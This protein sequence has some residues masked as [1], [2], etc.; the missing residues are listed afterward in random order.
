M[1][2]SPHLQPL[3]DRL[4]QLSGLA[5]TL[6]TVYHLEKFPVTDA[7]SV[8]EHPPGHGVAQDL[9]FGTQRLLVGQRLCCLGFCRIA[10]RGAEEIELLRAFTMARPTPCSRSLDQPTAFTFD[11]RAAMAR[12]IPLTSSSLALDDGSGRTALDNRATAD[13]V[14]YP[15]HRFAIDG[16]RARATDHGSTSMNRA[17]VRVADENDGFHVW[18]PLLKRRRAPPATGCAIGSEWQ[19]QCQAVRGHVVVG[20]GL[21]IA[22]LNAPA[23]RAAAGRCAR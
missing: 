20:I 3:G 17:T 15:G 12:G 5:C 16:G 9:L 21:L 13:L 19:A 11:Q 22:M 4:R 1:L 8:V 2:L 23:L 14:T 7:P 10:R 18:F 6:S